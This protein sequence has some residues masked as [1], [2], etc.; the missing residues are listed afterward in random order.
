MGSS[1]SGQENRSYASQLESP[2]SYILL[3]DRDWERNIRHIYV[4]RVPPNYCKVFA[5]TSG[6][7]LREIVFSRRII[8][9]MKSHTVATRRLHRSSNTNASKCHVLA[10]ALPGCFFQWTGLYAQHVADVWDAQR[11][12]LLQL[13][14]TL[15]TDI[16]QLDAEN[17]MA[18][19]A[20]A[21]DMVKLLN[22]IELIDWIT[23]SGDNNT[24]P[25]TVGAF[26][27]RPCGHGWYDMYHR[28]RYMYNFGN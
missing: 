7:F 17:L 25:Q 18:K 19:A 23:V 4:Q 27:P 9:T 15:V 8:S 28:T 1:S 3:L 10:A 16:W 13:P 20:D 24:I 5:L 11:K 6:T 21:D 14:N 26:R 22:T 12:G 2:Q